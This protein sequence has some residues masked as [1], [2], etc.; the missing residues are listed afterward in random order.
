ME[1]TRIVNIQTSRS[2]LYTVENYFPSEYAKIL[3]E[4]CKQLDLEVEPQMK[5]GT[6]HRCVGFFSDVSEGYQFSGQTA[7]IVTIARIS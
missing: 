4:K 3:F 2:Y 6:A 5:M 1:L 7:K